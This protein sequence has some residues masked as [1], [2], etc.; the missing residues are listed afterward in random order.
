MD[1]LPFCTSDCIC[2][3]EFLFLVDTSHCLCLRYAGLGGG[4]YYRKCHAFMK[5][6]RRVHECLSRSSTAINSGHSCFIFL[7]IPPPTGLGFWVFF[8]SPPF[9]LFFES[10]RVGACKLGRG[11]GRRKENLK[12][13]RLPCLPRPEPLVELSL[14]TLRS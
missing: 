9:N 3:V 11:R 13:T 4:S 10:G 7:L 8:F 2:N 1:P 6:D 5:V 14:I 12:Q